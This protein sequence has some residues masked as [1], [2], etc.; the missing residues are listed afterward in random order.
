M[1]EPNDLYFEQ[2]KL[3]RDEI[4]HH[5]SAIQK[6]EVYAIAFIAALYAWLSANGLVDIRVWF[7]G[8]FI[9]IFFGI[10]SYAL[11]HRIRQIAE[12][13]RDI[14]KIIFKDDSLEGWERTF[15]A[16]YSKGIVSSISKAFWLVLT[17]VTILAPFVLYKG[18]SN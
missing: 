6:L 10:R 12:Y 5:N 9:P 1:S 4:M 7:I 16:K 8:L 17:I 13:L 15:K 14:E 3:L 18:A 2:Y 11:L